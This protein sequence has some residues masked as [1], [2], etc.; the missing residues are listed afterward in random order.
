MV[1]MYN[2]SACACKKIKENCPLPKLTVQFPPSKR[3]HHRFTKLFSD[4]SAK[5]F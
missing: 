2:H 1:D 3:F 5:R 4:P